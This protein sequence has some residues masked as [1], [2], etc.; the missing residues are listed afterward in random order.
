MYLAKT[1]NFSSN[2]GSNPVFRISKVVPEANMYLEIICSNSEVQASR[3]I[4]L[5]ERRKSLV[6]D[7]I[8]LTEITKFEDHQKITIKYLLYD[9]LLERLSRIE[10]EEQEVVTCSAIRKF[11]ILLD[12]FEFGSY[13]DLFDICWNE[14]GFY[15]KTSLWIKLEFAKAIVYR[16]LYAPLDLSKIERGSIE[17]LTTLLLKIRKESLDKLSIAPELPC[18]A[19]AADAILAV[20]LLN[21]LSSKIELDFLSNLIY[22]DCVPKWLSELICYHIEDSLEYIKDE[23][24]ANN[25]KL[26]ISELKGKL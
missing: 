12:E 17:K 15:D 3:I 21:S 24:F 16:M 2:T 11:A 19:A 5:L 18:G 10:N 20:V 4:G 26:L 7:L 8:L 13:F 1:L 6:D 25:I 22:E 23:L 14:L 9:I